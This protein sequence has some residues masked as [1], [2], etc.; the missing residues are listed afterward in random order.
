MI[1]FENVTKIYNPS[2]SNFPAAVALD[3]VSFEI[4]KT[5]FISLVGRSGAG[6]T[7]LLR[8]LLGEEKPTKGHV[9]FDNQDVHKIR[10]SHLPRLRKKIGAVFQ[11]YKLLPLKTTYENIAYVME[12]MGVNDKE[13]SRDVHQVLEIVGLTD[14]ANNFPKELSG[15]EKQRAAIARAL[16]H[17]P[18][19]ILADE[20][21]GNL[22]PY[23]ASDVIR[24]LLKINEL[25]TTVILAS[26]NKEIVNSLGRRVI[27]L[28]NG[29]IVR[30]EEKGRFAL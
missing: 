22:D 13:I 8:L 21:T 1:K 17:R 30:D 7:T 23:N 4:N 16:I 2:R 24:L 11:D 5:E 20:P 19:V 26:H 6:K 18:E 12:V 15:G 28:E 10:K 27:T 25:G 3:D 29:K 14:K 9:F